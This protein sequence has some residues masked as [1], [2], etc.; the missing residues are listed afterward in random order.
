M[1]AWVLGNQRLVRSPVWL[2]QHGLGWLL[3]SRVLMLEHIGRRSGQPRYV[4]L[5]VVERPAVERIVVVSG[6]GDRA[7]WYRNLAHDQRCWVSV[8]RLVRRP[9]R[10]YLMSP[11][12]SA[13]VLG[14]YQAS[15][16][17]AW[18]R[19][20]DSIEEATGEPVT[21]LPMVQLELT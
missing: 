13:A 5:E 4:C 6:F 2:Y 21:G 20:R 7:Q 19:V 9:A 3:G 11:A 17:A 1:G 8:G 18:Q 10:A 12:D 14:R 16:P 15:H